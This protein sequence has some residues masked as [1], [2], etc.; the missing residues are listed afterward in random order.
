MKSIFLQRGVGG[1]LVYQF[2]TQQKADIN[3][4]INTNLARILCLH[5]PFKPS[6]NYIFL[7]FWVNFLRT[8]SSSLSLSRCPDEKEKAKINSEELQI[9]KVK[10]KKKKK[11][12][13]GEK[14]KRVKMY[15][16]SCQ[17]I[18]A[19]L[20]LLPP[21]SPSPTSSSSASNPT[22]N[23]SHSPFKSPLPVYP[24]SNSK[25]SHLLPSSPPPASKS[26]FNS[27]LHNTS[28]S[29]LSSIKTALPSPTKQQQT[30]TYP[31]MA[32]LEFAPYIHIENQP[33]GGALVAH[34]YTSQL[35]SL[36]M[37]QRQRFAQEF[38]KLAF[39]EDSSQVWHRYRSDWSMDFVFS[40]AWSICNINAVKLFF[41]SL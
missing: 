35:S 36:S 28:N 33:N 12:K 24:S 39:S 31:G 26:L 8:P 30:C 6:Q 20:L 37:G 17:T 22:H 10:K 15:H 29:P 13:E 2:I 7:I 38:V 9:K 32:G 41:F 19:G 27:S 34:A 21:S 18:C 40:A 1:V 3:R 23:S 16:R 4:N 11:H 5:T 25:T 14:H